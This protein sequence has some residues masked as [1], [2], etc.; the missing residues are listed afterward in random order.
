MPKQHPKISQKVANMAS[1]S[2]Q[3]GAML[4]SKTVLDAAKS[5]EKQQTKTPSKKQPKTAPKRQPKT[6]PGRVRPGLA[7]N[8]KSEKGCKTLQN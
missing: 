2:T 4:G 7:W 5:E 6:A 1:K 8:G 3:V